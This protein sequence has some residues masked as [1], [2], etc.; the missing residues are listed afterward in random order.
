[1]PWRQHVAALIAPRLGRAR[2]NKSG[3]SAGTSGDGGATPSGGSTSTS[4]TGGTQGGTSRAQGG[5]GGGR[6]RGSAGLRR[7]RVGR[8][9]VLDGG[10]ARDL[11]IDRQRSEDAGRHPRG[12]V[13]DD[14]CRHRCCS[15][16]GEEAVRVPELAKTRRNDERLFRDA[17]VDGIG[18]YGGFDCETWSY[19]ATPQGL[20]SFLERAEQGTRKTKALVA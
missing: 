11:R 12:P 4:G 18:I 9:R 5:Q 7:R 17:S 1:L 15:E 19:S 2:R 14:R 10:R 6:R 16:G 3:N 8:R 20:M 13:Q